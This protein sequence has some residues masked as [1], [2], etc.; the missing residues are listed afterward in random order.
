MRAL[1]IAALLLGAGAVGAAEDP[2]RVPWVRA[3]FENGASLRL[4]TCATN[5]ERSRGMMFRK[6][7]PEGWGMLFAFER[8]DYLSF[9]MR[10]TYVPLSIA[11]V[12]PQGVITNIR[13]MRPLDEIT[14]HRS[15]RKA[16]FAIEVRQGW[17][18]DNGIRAGQRV[19]LLRNRLL[20]GE[21]RPR[22]PGADELHPQAAGPGQ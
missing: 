17:F 10:N 16:M 3:V 15:T 12:D 13:N 2:A 22:M 18:R 9:W 19:N 7:A 21:T 8:P 5:Q 1:W 20:P 14:R 6:E 11:F 4:E